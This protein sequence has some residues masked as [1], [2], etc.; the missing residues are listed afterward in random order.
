MPRPDCRIADASIVAVATGYAIEPGIA[1]GHERAGAVGGTFQI[2]TGRRMKGWYRAFVV[3]HDVA[4]RG[5]RIPGSA[6]Q[7]V[8]RAP[9][10]H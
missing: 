7:G 3:R 10:S 9:I 4:S 8:C 5:S 1:I 6:R 2:L